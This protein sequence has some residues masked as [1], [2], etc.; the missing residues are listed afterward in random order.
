MKQPKWWKK[1]DW[2]QSRRLLVGSVLVFLA[3]FLL[4]WGF[5]NSHPVVFQVLTGLGL[6]VLAAG[7]V[8]NLLFCRCP[9]CGRSLSNLRLQPAEFCPYCGKRL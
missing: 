9:H 7:G 3:L 1:P 5:E 2:R 6:A 8:Q 4:G